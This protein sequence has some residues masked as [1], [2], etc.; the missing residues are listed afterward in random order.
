MQKCLL[1]ISLISSAAV[2]GDFSS[3]PAIDVDFTKGQQLDPSQWTRT[4]GVNNN[5][6]VF[7]TDGDQN[8][9]YDGKSLTLEARKEQ[10]N[11][12][13]YKNASAGSI[14][15]IPSRDISSASV[16]TKN[17]F[18]YGKVEVVAKTPESPGLQPAIWLQG[19]NK[20]QYGEIDIMEVPG[21][22]KPGFRF[23]TVHAGESPT[24]LTR[25][26]GA[27]Q[28]DDGFHTYTAEWTPVSIKILYDGKQVLEVPSNLAD[29]GKI[30]PLNQPMQLKINIGAG[31]GWSGPVDTAKLPQQM[32]VKSVKVWEYSGS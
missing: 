9:S 6:T 14:K 19:E 16:A 5:T 2:A 28:L 27:G 15:D 8:I 17:Y 18:K 22:K 21:T 12:P 23:A 29:D 10:I 24:K 25:K 30:S 31:T 11:N 1:A 4:V 32:Q 7:Y 3:S 13:K 26:S 20:G